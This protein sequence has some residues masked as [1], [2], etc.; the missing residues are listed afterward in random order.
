MLQPPF[1]TPT[2]AVPLQGVSMSVT[3]LQAASDLP[4]PAFLR[5]AQ[6]LAIVL[7]SDATLWRMVKAGRF[8]KP[9]KLSANVTACPRLISVGFDLFKKADDQGRS[10]RTLTPGQNSSQDHRANE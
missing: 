9:C 2:A 3:A 1:L 4:P 5:Q 7:V 10:G 6:V 8:P